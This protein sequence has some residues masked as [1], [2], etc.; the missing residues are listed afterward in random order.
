MDRWATFDCYGTLIDWDGGVRAQLGAMFPDADRALARY[1]AVEPGLQAGGQRT[2]RQVLTDVVP[3]IAEAEGWPVPDDPAALADSLPTWQP[4]GEVPAVMPELRERGWRL[5]ILSNTDPDYL[6]ASLALIGVPVDVRVTA[7]EIGSYKPAVA[8]WETFFRRTGA[9]RR[10]H[11]HVA[12]SLFHDVQPCAALGLPCV[13][14]NRTGETSG[15]PRAGELP[16]LAGLPDLLD[17]LVP[18]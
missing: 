15:L 10:G 18:A 3:G 2:Y 4:F 8:H 12:A 16:S 13:W 11:V 6:D 14:I 1:H 7:S 5:G 17:D 9:D